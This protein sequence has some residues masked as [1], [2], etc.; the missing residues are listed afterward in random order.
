MAEYRQQRRKGY[1][2]VAAEVSNGLPEARDLTWDDDFFED[3]DEDAGLIAVFDFDYALASQFK[4]AV[5]ILTKMVVILG[6]TF[7]S[8]VITGFDEQLALPI[9]GGGLAW[10]LV[11]VALTKFQ[12]PWEVY[13]QHLA[14]TRDGIR[15]VNDKRKSCWGLPIC[16]KGRNS[17][18]VPFD[19]ITDCDIT[20]PAGNSCCCIQNVLATV[21]VDTAS[22]GSESRRH[23]LSIVGLVDPY[24]F[25]KL[26]WAVKRAK[27]SGGTLAYRAPSTSRTPATTVE[28]AVLA[29]DADA[30]ADLEAG[31]PGANA[32]E[33]PGLLRD[34]R[35][36]LRQNND[37]LRRQRKEERPIELV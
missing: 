30:I 20:E 34:I 2:S 36:E 14:V 25:K 16:D 17:K 37:L 3:D 35:D 22:S 24:S 31:C 27:E 28:M 18:T 19:K 11:A 26:V 6:V 13:A 23:E 1:F 15:F 10:C 4:T 12:V 32:S 7:Y 5:T 21:N 9:A 33:I 29:G 8:V